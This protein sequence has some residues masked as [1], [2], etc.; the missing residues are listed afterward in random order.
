[1]ELDEI[2]N[3]I[4]SRLSQEQV[5]EIFLGAGCKEPR[6]MKVKSNGWTTIRC[7]G[8]EDEENQKTGKRASFYA[9]LDTGAYR[10]KSCGRSGN[11]ITIA[12]LAINTSSGKEAL[13]FLADEAG[14]TLDDRTEYE[15]PVPRPKP[16][17]KPIEYIRFNPE[18]AVLN[19]EVDQWFGKL[20]QMTDVQQYKLL[21][22]AV[23]R[24][25]LKTDQ[26]KKL[27]YYSGRKITNP[28]TQLIGFLHKDD[29][30]FWRPIEEQFGLDL[31]IKFGLYN[32]AHHKRSPLSFKFLWLDV[33]FV[34]SFDLY[35]DMITGAM[36]RPIVKQ[37]KAK[38]F[39]L[40]K[41]TIVEPIPFA[42]TH[43][44]LAYSD[45]PIW[46]TEGSVDGLSLG[47]SRVFASIPGVDGI[48]DEM[49]G[50]FYGKTVV[51]ALDSDRPGQDALY[52]YLDKKDGKFHKG[53]I[54]RLRDAGVAKIY[55]ARW[56]IELGKDLNDLLKAGHLNKIS[57]CEVSN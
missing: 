14:V 36:L 13:Q 38:E 27:T 49:L 17:P 40:S 19:V 25:S 34:P 30:E 44:I 41:H 47:A 43:D 52:G 51:L 4:T 23:Y 2:V 15:K 6:K 39:S 45:E 24:A 46:I 56:D 37:P 8:H 12:K 42:L 32:D 54:D 7:Y 22:T 33:N 3:R 16:Q 29:V 53:F 28:R 21:M 55:V 11:L 26:S 57:V 50:L 20:G 1:M 9:N 18:R 35:T 31:L 48:A 5:L 10:C